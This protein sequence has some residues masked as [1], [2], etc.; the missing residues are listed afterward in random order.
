MRLYVMRHS[1]TDWNRA[2]RTQGHADVHLNA[3]GMKIAALTGDGMADIPIDLCY[4]SPLARAQETAALV[5]SR[6]KYFIEHGAITKLDKRIEEIDFGIWEGRLSNPAAGEIDKKEFHMYFKEKDPEFI[7]EGA[8]T[9]ES[10]IRRTADFLD[11]LNSKPEHKDKTILVVTHG[12]A[13]KCMLRRFS[14][15]PDYF[16]K[17]SVPYN[18]EVTIIDSSPDGKLAVTERHKLFYDKALAENLYGMK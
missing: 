5:L 3:N 14:D 7:P 4:T 11:D 10:V 8:E 1:E 12:C 13:L 17:G 16:A 9:L 6:N 2:G 18:C 15:D